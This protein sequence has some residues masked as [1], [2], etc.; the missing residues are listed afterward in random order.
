[1]ETTH[2]PHC[3]ADTEQELTAVDQLALQ[4]YASNGPTN[5]GFQPYACSGD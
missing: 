4:R 2:Q 5:D 1:V 3:F